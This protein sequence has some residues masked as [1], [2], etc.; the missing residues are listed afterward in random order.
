MTLDLEK[1]LDACDHNNTIGGDVIPFMEKWYERAGFKSEWE[2][3]HTMLSLY[4]LQQ[5][6]LP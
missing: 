2:T 4:K 3:H 1:S 6:L 5:S